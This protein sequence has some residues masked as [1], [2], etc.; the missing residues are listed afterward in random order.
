MPPPGSPSGL[1]LYFNEIA[2][3]PL[4]T[5]E[6]EQMLAERMRCGDESSFCT[7]VKAHLRFVVSVAR[8]Y[9]HTGVALSDLISAGNVGL[10]RGVRAYD[11]SR[12]TRLISYAVWWVRQGIL[13]MLAEQ[14]RPVNIPLNRAVTV[15]QITRRMRQAEQVMQRPVSA[16]EFCEEFDLS[17]DAYGAAAGLTR[18]SLSLDAPVG[19]DDQRSIGDM[20]SEHVSTPPDSPLQREIRLDAE[21][22]LAALPTRERDVLERLYGLDG[23]SPHTLQEVADTRGLTRERVRQIRNAALRR[24]RNRENVRSAV[25]T[26]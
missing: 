26:A 24:L 9:E 10:I 17:P 3:Y 7:L 15:T 4:I 25:A 23:T 12:G 20:L 14:S 1:S 21:A 5:R 13:Q 18:R 16:E 2:K 22:L 6:E 8:K 11:P 19:N